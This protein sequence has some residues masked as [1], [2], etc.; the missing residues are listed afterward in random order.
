MLYV[1]IGAFL[2]DWYTYQLL[3]QYNT[4]KLTV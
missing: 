1:R 3:S 2:K 4:N